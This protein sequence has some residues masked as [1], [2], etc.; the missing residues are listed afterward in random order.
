M[1]FLFSR[2]L[3]SWK[4]QGWKL[5]WTSLSS[6]RQCSSSQ[7]AIALTARRQSRS[8]LNTN[9]KD[10]SQIQ[11]STNTKSYCL[12]FKWTQVLAK[13]N[14]DP[15]KFE[16]IEIDQRKDMDKIQAYMKK[17]TVK[18]LQ[19]W[20][21]IFNNVKISADWSIVSSSAFH[22]RAVHWW[23]RRYCCCSQVQN[24]L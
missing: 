2:F 24:L 11:K 10:K 12:D 22:R 9:F 15:E 20:K 7:R 6:P 13:Y 5:R 23:G 18:Y 14:I 17:V 19:N 16:V 4:C 21:R 3:S 8:S 1:F